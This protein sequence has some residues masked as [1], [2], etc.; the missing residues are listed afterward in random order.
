MYWT[1][2]IVCNFCV[3]YRLENAVYLWKCSHLCQL[4]SVEVANRCQCIYQTWKGFIRTQCSISDLLHCGYLWS[5]ASMGNKYMLLHPCSCNNRFIRTK[6]EGHRPQGAVCINLLLHEQGCNNE[7]I[8]GWSHA[9][10]DIYRH[11]W[12]YTKSTQERAVQ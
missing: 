9:Y 4:V 2:A 7:F 12:T 1:I 5:M 8:S 3:L 11:I 6:P 10:M